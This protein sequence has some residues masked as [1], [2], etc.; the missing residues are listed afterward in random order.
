VPA[1]TGYFGSGPTTEVVISLDHNVGEGEQRRRNGKAERFR[2]PHV[3][4]ELELC[5]LFDRKIG[6]A[7]VKQVAYPS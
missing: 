2:R 7:D 1:T 4:H 6:G 3:Q 5:W